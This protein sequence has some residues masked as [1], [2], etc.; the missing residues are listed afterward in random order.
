MRGRRPGGLLSAPSLTDSE[1]DEGGDAMG[2]GQVAQLKAEL[3]AVRNELCNTVSVLKV[4][5]CVFVV[6][7]KQA[8]S[9]QLVHV[10]AICM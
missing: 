1:T 5:V 9:C 6:C 3:K 2:M 10:H 4:C 7:I 8:S